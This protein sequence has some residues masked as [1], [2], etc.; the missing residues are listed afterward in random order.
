VL[1]PEGCAIVGGGYGPNTPQNLIDDI[2]EESKQLNLL[3]G[4]QWMSKEDLTQMIQEASLQEDAEIST[5]GGLWVILRK[6]GDSEEIPQLGD[7]LS[8]GSHEIIA[9]TGGGGKTTLM[10]ALA[11]ELCARGFKVLTT[12]TTKIFEPAQEQAP[13]LVIEA[14]QGKAMASVKEGL[15]QNGHVTFAAHRFPEG[16]IGGVDPQFIEQMAQELLVDHIIV[17]A[18]GAKRLPLKAPGDQEPV[19]PSVTTLVIPIIGIDAVGKPLNEETAFR[20][21][22]VAEL[23]GTT[24]GDPITPQLIASLIIH[25]Q[26]LCKGIP[27]GV[28]IIPFINK[29][30]TAEGLLR[31]R[32]IAQEVLEKGDEIKKVVLGRL[33]FH[34]PIVELIERRS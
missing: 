31:A 32:E 33:F 25:P 15:L 2:A 9:L 23:T 12:T 5:E 16:K 28:R 7:A 10:F 24:L 1:R 34:H 13:S 14:D 27:R 17:E 3:L 21:E 11:E 29:V 6:E 4:K 8:L 20:P 22:R 26:G 18:D 30:E 19:I